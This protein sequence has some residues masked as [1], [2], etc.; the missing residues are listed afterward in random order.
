MRN[1][2]SPGSI[3][4]GSFAARVNFIT[5]PGP[6]RVAADDLDKDGKTDLVVATFQ[7]GGVSVLR[8]TGQPGVINSNTFAP[9]VDF[10]TGAGVWEVQVGDIDMD[11]RPEIVTANYTARTVSV[12]RNQ[13]T[14]GSLTV[15][16]FAPRVNFPVGDS[17]AVAIG[18]LNGDGKAEL[19]VANFSSNNISVF[20]NV[21]TPGSFASNSFAPPVLFATGSGPHGVAIGDVDGDGRPDLAISAY[22]IS[23][24]SLLRNMGA[25]GSII[26]SNSFAAKVDFTC[27]ANPQM[28]ALA[29]LNGDGRPDLATTSWGGSLFSV[30]QNITPLSPPA[31]TQQP[32]SQ[33]IIAG[34]PVIF[35]SS[36]TGSAPLFYQWFFS[37]GVRAIPGA[38]NSSLS[39]PFGLFSAGPRGYLVT[40]SNSLGTAQSSNATLTVITPQCT[41]PPSGLVGWWPGNNNSFDSVGTNHGAAQSGV[42]FATGKAGQ[43]FLLGVTNNGVRIPASAALNVG[44][45]G[46]MTIECWVN[47]ATV[48]GNNPL[49]EWNDGDEATG[50]FWGVHLFVGSFG[51]GSLYANVVGPGETWHQLN[52][53]AGVVKTNTF[54]HVALTYDKASGVARIFCNGAVVA[55]QFIGSFT[56]LTDT[57]LYLGKRPAGSGV[58]N[59]VG[60]MDEVALYNR[61]LTP[62]EIAAIYAARGTGKCPLSPTILS[63]TPPGWNVNEGQTVSFSAVAT[64]TTPLSYQW[65]HGG[66]PI[67]GATA[68]SLVLSN[69]LFAQA[70]NYSVLVSNIAGTATSSNVVLDVNR[71][72]VADASATDA[73]VVAPLN[74]DGVSLASVVL[75]GSNSS[76]PDADGL[77]YSWFQDGVSNAIATGVVAVVQLPAGS[78][79]LTLVVSDGMASSSQ[80]FVV[81][82]ITTDTAV[83]RLMAVVQANADRPQPLIASLRAALA[84][85]DRCQPEVAINHLE[86]FKNKVLAQVAPNDPELANLLLGEA[87]ALIDILNGGAAPAAALEITEISQGNNGKPHLKIRGASGRVHIIETSVDMVNWVKIGVAGCNGGCDYEFNDAQTPDAGARFYR[88]VSPR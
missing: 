82:V 77:T 79:H 17:Y 81:E 33:T 5:G 20:R 56:P 27:S 64:G 80:S 45:G 58:F 52:S 60:L 67:S 47:L 12:L 8:N 65:L 74:C 36:A 16:S 28:V 63:V 75:D 42:G 4:A 44:T 2:S 59:S 7:G 3:T 48:T 18:D 14:P 61:A 55:Q 69:V 71:A 76:D 38:T 11:G 68:S 35:N 6:V 73:L 66:N 37:D 29:D 10:A 19:T 84:S 40:V 50:G 70:G 32:V 43:A 53:A 46:G 1:L 87:Q 24:A 62:N 41:A 88:V 25:P 83:E 30:M 31:F 78:N 51:A 23:K 13:S 9:K 54:Q 72:P 49:I 86:A 21:S 22:N 26:N 34:D 39:L 15:N 85:I 57:D